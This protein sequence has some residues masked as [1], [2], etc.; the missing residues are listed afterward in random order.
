[1][2]SQASRLSFLLVVFNYSDLDLH[3]VQRAVA[4]ILI[5]AFSAQA[6]NQGLYYLDYSINRA[7]YV[8]NC[9][10]KA[11]PQLRCNGKCQLMKKILEQEKKEQQQAPEMKLAS[12]FEVI[13]SKSFF[14]EY[15]PLF[16][17]TALHRFS[18]AVAEPPVDRAF[19]IFHPPNNSLVQA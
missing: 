15:H 18:V 1:M 14:A 8:K 7:A 19:A 16:I 10:N 12:K 13:S 2:L 11:R 17:T 4:F 9:I 3:I 6:F 5:I